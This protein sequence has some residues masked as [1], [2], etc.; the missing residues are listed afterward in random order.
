MTELVR[1]ETLAE[2]HHFNDHVFRQVAPYLGRRVLEVGTGIGTFTERLL[3]R[4]DE[5]VGIDIVREFVTIARER[6]R[7]RPNVEV[8]EADMGATGTTAATGA[9]ASSRRSRA[10]ASRW[11][12]RP[13]STWPASSAGS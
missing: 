7:D 4:C 10:P 1:L 12:T 5:V 6:L 8:F 13:P 9:R 2:A 3:E 11:P